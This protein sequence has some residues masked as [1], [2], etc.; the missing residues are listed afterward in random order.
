MLAPPNSR[1]PGNAVQ[2]ARDAMICLS[3]E[4]MHSSMSQA[5]LDRLDRLNKI[6]VALSAEKDMP[7]LLEMILLGAQAITRADGGTLYTMTP[8]RSLRFE[9]I[10][11]DS[12]H[13]AMGGTGGV[14]IPFPPIE[15]YNQD[16]QPNDRMVVA[17][18]V[19]HDC[20]VNIADAYSEAGFDFSGTRTFDA[21]TGYRSQSF[22]TIP[23]K[24]HENDIIGVLQLINKQDPHSGAIVAFDDADRRLAESLASQAAV[25]LTNKKLIAELNGLFEAFIQLIAAAIDEKSP[26]TGG[27][28]RRVPVL[29]LML[30]EAASGVQTGSLKDFTLTQPDRYE[31]SIAAWLHDC[32]KITTPEHVV[33]KSTKLETLFDRIHRVDVCF[34][35]VQRDAEIER[36]RRQ[37]ALAKNSQQQE[38]IPADEQD[39]AMS[40]QLMDERDFLRRANLG[41][42]FMS[43]ADQERVRTIATRSWIDLDGKPRSLLTENEVENLCIARGTLTPAERAVINKH[44]SATIKM[45][46]SLPFPKHLRRVPEYAGGHHERMDGKGYPR[47]LTRE[48]MS[49][50]A[51]VMAI[52]DIFEALTAADRPYKKAKPLSESLGILGRMKREQHIDAELFDVFLDQKVYLHYAQQYLQPEQIDIHEPHE[53]PG[54]PFE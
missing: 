35:I 7:Q 15:L 54:Y 40:T 18:A 41:G 25:A 6:G 3:D 13:I 2:F 37:L 19:L 12:R 17:Y 29:T 49:V 52:A 24:N 11:T 45:L 22:L 48:Q 43:A 26:Y 38:T 20:T 30:A 16:Q 10:R 34:E 46:E 1:A 4:P 14:P 5:T 27:H 53:I 9:I 23:M 32:G 31:L 33:D 47:G 44:I 36:L 50:P 8:Q 21:Q 39:A 51:R 42:E 28:C